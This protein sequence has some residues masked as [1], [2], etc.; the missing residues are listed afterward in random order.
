MIKLTEGMTNAIKENSVSLES[1]Y[2]CLKDIKN[3]YSTAKENKS[4]IEYF[5]IIL[6][7]YWGADPLYL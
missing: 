4:K 5:D 7:K 2:N 3:L 1:I 6:S